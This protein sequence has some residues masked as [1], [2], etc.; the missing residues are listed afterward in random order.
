MAQQPVPMGIPTPAAPPPMPSASAPPPPPPPVVASPVLPPPPPGGVDVAR[1]QNLAQAPGAFNDP[2][3]HVAGEAM[4]QGVTVFLF[5]GVGTWKTTWA[6]L[7]PKPIFLSVGQE[8]GDDALTQLPAL[9]GVK[10]PRV[11]AIKSPKQMLDKVNQIAVRYPEMGVDTV[12]VDSLTYYVDMWIAELNEIRY[13]DPKIKAMIDKKG[14]DAAAMTMRDWGLLA[15]HITKDIAMKLH[16]TP[17]NVIWIALEKE[18]KEQNEQMGSSRVIAVEPYVR[19][20][21]AVKLP[22][23]CKMIIHANRE[24]IPDPQNPGRMMTRP[25]YYTSPN[26]LTKIVRHKYGNC[27]PEGKLVNLQADGSIDP[28]LGDLPTFNSIWSRIGKFVHYTG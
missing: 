27:F 26:H 22:G 14:G 21:T 18:I 25:V 5:G 3:L 23:M 10:P 11:Y 16:R 6:G 2:D 9:Y 20:E 4:T 17:L 19:G 12:V 13:N 1:F 7:W 8:G 28:K 15:M 24:M